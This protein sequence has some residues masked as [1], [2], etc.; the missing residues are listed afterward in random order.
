MSAPV[1]DSSPDSGEHIKREEGSLLILNEKLSVLKDT[2]AQDHIKTQNIRARSEIDVGDSVRSCSGLE[3]TDS[4][5][6]SIA[7]KSNEER[8]KNM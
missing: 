8:A 3:Y 4:L 5:T 7:P 2:L 6:R 1:R